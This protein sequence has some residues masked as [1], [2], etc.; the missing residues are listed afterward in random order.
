M[1]VVFVVVVV[2]VV[3]IVVLVKVPGLVLWTVVVAV[4]VLGVEDCVE[5]SVRTFVL[6][7]GSPF[8]GVKMRCRWFVS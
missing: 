7:S 1:S 8:Y 2:L 6:V 3:L 5:P 4:V